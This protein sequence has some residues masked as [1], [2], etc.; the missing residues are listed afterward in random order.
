MVERRLVVSASQLEL[1]ILI[2]CSIY[3]TM[4]PI[5]YVSIKDIL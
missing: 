5:A 3:H 1:I 2:C 4:P